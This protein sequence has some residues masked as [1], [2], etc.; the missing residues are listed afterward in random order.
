MNQA[1]ADLNA[2]QRGLAQQYP[3][4]RYRPGV[5]MAAMLDDAVSNARSG[6]IFLFAAVGVVLIIGCTNV[7]GLLLARASSRRGEVAV[8]AALGASRL[9]LL[10]QFLLESLLLAVAGGAAGIV[11][12]F[13]LLRLGLQIVP[14]DL[15]RLYSVAMDGRVL[16]FAILLSASTALIFGLLPAWKVSQLSPSLNLLRRRKRGT[17]I[18]GRRFGNFWN[19]FPVE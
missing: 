15:P 3:E 19:G 9:R 17:A 12:S 16:I 14:F 8:R 1:L 5:Q 18:G 13:F 7:A 11:I 2:I 10:R 6:L 4:N